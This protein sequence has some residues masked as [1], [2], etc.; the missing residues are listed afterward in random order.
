MAQR[1]SM[2]EVAYAAG[3]RV[4]IDVW[5][6]QN[7]GLLCFRDKGIEARYNASLT[8]ILAGNV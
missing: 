1:F 5:R 3:I 6:D 7:L 4:D 8:R 2:D